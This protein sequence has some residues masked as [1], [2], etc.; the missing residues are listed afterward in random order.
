MPRQDILKFF[1]FPQRFSRSRTPESAELWTAGLEQIALPRVAS[2]SSGG[3]REAQIRAW[4]AAGMEIGAQEHH[5]A[6]PADH[7]RP[8]GL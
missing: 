4:H 7:L 2:S 1:R 5:R 3:F 8:G 6:R